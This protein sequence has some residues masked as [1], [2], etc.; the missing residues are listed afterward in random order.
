MANFHV[1]GLNVNPSCLSHL[2]GLNMNGLSL[3]GLSLNGLNMNGLCLNGLDI[4]GL[5][6]NGV[7]MNGM[8]GLNKTVSLFVDLPRNDYHYFDLPFIKEEIESIKQLT[9]T[10]ILVPSKAVDYIQNNLSIS[11]PA[12]MVQQALELIVN[13]IPLA[14]E[15]DYTISCFESESL[16]KREALNQIESIA[17]KYEVVIRLAKIGKENDKNSKHND[18]NDNEIE[19][20]KVVIKGANNY[21]GRRNIKNAYD[22]LVKLI[23]EYNGRPSDFIQTEISISPQFDDHNPGRRNSFLDSINNGAQITIK[24]EA[25][26][27]LVSISANSFDIL[28]EALLQVFKKTVIELEFNISENESCWL[29]RF[30]VDSLA[31]NLNVHIFIKP[32]LAQGQK[33]VMIRGIIDTPKPLFEARDW[34]L[35]HLRYF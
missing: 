5:C 30:P 3:N 15:F 25:T 10:N 33:T 23:K 17:Q 16:Q 8:N 27:T 22:D 6:L 31:A 19:V 18:F 14:I 20:Y 11:G 28:I 26:L 32:S 9:S 12:Y 35:S 1:N 2:D 4:N 29:K 24:K 7:N 13:F 21:E 34:I